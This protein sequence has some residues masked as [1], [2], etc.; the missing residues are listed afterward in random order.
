MSVQYNP[1]LVTDSLIFSLDAANKKSYVD[2]STVNLFPAYGTSGSGSGSNNNVYFDVNA[3]GYF[4][5]M[6]YGQTFGGYTIQQSDVVYKWD[7]S[8]FQN[9]CN[10][11]GQRINV[12]KG[13]YIKWTFDYYID[14]SC[15]GVTSGAYLANMEGYGGGAVY[16]QFTI[17]NNTLGTWQTMTIQYGPYNSDGVQAC[18]MYPGGCGNNLAT[19]GFMLFRNPTV[20]LI[21]GSWNDLNNETNSP[22]LYDESNT[23]IGWAPYS[24]DGGGSWDFANAQSPNGIWSS[25]S[26]YGF[27]MNNNPLPTTGG[28]TLST[29]IKNPN[30]NGQIGMISFGG[31]DGMRFGPTTFGTYILM[32]PTYTEGYV[33]YNQ[34]YSNS[35][36]TTGWHNVTAVFDRDG[37][38]SSG[39]PEVGVYLN[40]VYKGAMTLPSPQTAFTPA[41]IGIVRSS[42]CYVFKGKISTISAYSKAL[43]SEEV[44]LNF[45]ATRSRFGI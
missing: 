22:T 20:N 2:T 27:I 11:H 31:S 37:R 10:Y 15:T 34:D 28:F 44:M 18:F 38:L 21:N 1:K 24:S 4:T 13:Q 6:G 29:W 41:S 35:S 5:R 33:Y 8:V 9:G 30:N 7:M 32:G 16:S 45:N 36:L 39:V 19:S 40:G 14:T 12:K 23:T 17:P 3:A 43:S 26:R 25:W 42:C